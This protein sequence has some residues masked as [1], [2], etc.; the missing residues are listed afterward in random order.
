MEK[1]IE[2]IQT[3][4]ESVL[5]KISEN[6]AMFLWCFHLILKQ[7]KI[8][9]RETIVCQNGNFWPNWAIFDQN[10]AYLY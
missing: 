10:M 5:K 4:K 2:S 9:T 6:K 8:K 7:S 1:N 3:R